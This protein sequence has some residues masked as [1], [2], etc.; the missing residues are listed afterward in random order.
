MGDTKVETIARLAQW[1]IET[2]GLTTAY[3]RSD[4]FKI[5]MWNWYTYLQYYL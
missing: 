2:F 1:K 3:K 4:P 5:G